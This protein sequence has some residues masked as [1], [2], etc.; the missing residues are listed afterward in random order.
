MDD[1]SKLVTQD[2]MLYKWDF[3]GADQMCFS[4][5]NCES[6]IK[7]AKFLGGGQVE[8]WGCGTGWAKQYFKDYKGIDGSPSKV[9]SKEDVVDLV[10]Y[11]SSVDNILIRQVLECNVDWRKILENVKKSFKKKFCLV[12]YTPI[13]LVETKVLADY[14]IT[15]ADGIVVS[16]YTIPEI[17]FK[18]EEILAYFPT[19]EFKVSEETI[20]TNQGYGQEWILYVE[21]INVTKG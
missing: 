5:H 1:I 19:T 14:A 2:S 6:Y 7:S 9:V 18:K 12:I 21:R 20:K 10:N 15:K 4:D 17:T 16:T 3:S 13:D 8:D 11:T